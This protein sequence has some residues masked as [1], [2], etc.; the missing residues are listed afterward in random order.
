MA[1]YGLRSYFIKYD[2]FEWIELLPSPYLDVLFAA[3]IAAA[4]LFT[5]GYWFR[6]AGVVQFLGITY[7]FLSEQSIY[8]NHYYLF[9]LL[10]L[11]MIFTQADGMFS[12]KAWRSKSAVVE[13]PR[14]QLL[15]IQLQL[16][17]VY[18]FGGVA[19]LNPDWLL[20]AEPMQTWLPD[21]FG[22]A[23]NSLG[24]EA[25]NAWAY[26]F[27]YSG[28][29]IDLSVG[30]LLFHRH[31]KWLAMVVLVAFHTSNSFMFSIGYFP[32]FG[33]LS[34]VIFLS[35]PDINWLL[36]KLGQSKLP[37]LTTQLVKPASAVTLLFVLWFV[38]Q[39]LLPLRHFVMPGPVQWNM[40][41]YLFAWYMKLNDY[42]PI[43]RFEVE[44]PGSSQRYTFDLEEL[45][46]SASQRH[47]ICTHPFIAV[48]FAKDVEAHV[49]AQ[50]NISGDVK[51]FCDSYVSLNGRPFQR[52]I[53]PTVDLTAVELAPIGKYF[54]NHRW[55]I[56]MGN[57]TL[58]DR[59]IIYK[60]KQ[61][62]QRP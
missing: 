36:A 19:K 11:L 1:D 39:L 44:L 33:V 46:E 17:I 57:D 60:I 42:A 54:T 52:K 61:F 56:P 10:S 41:G 31:L 62:E 37:E 18:F 47:L 58:V 48:D 4:A 59:K 55:V 30:F 5:L 26:F 50:H 8:N 7:L 43:N 12:L 53:D 45:T 27:A 2:G 35:K 23:Y 34:L 28:L 13:V 29:I 9:C 22:D 6:V 51:V 25:A 16:F 40:N 32:L 3:W 24:A 21:M 14:W 38:I 49:K 15:F 20:H